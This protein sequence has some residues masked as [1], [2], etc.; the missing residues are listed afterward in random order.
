MKSDF[1]DHLSIFNY[2]LLATSIIRY[3]QPSQSL[4]R[5]ITYNNT[6]IGS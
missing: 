2:L 1:F 4:V 5:H 6:T 3:N